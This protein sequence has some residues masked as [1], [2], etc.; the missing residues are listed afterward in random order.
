ME[1]EKWHSTGMLIIAKLTLALFGI[2]TVCI[3][4]IKESDTLR[5]VQI[6]LLICSV[7]AA[8]TYM[9]SRDIT[10]VATLFVFATIFLLSNVVFKDIVVDENSLTTEGFASIIFAG[11]FLAMLIVLFII[12]DQPYIAENEVIS[13]AAYVLM[14]TVMKIAVILMSSWILWI[15]HN[16]LV[17]G[18]RLGFRAAFDFLT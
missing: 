3:P 14:T 18:F 13:S 6:V 8:V 12:A 17:S 1:Q 5:I 7:T 11:G 15:L 16:I 9:L 4:L 10:W 2:L